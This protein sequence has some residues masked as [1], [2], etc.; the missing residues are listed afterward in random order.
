MTTQTQPAPRRGDLLA[1]WGGILFSLAFT[2]VIA[3]AGWR[4]EAI[5]KWPDAGADWYFWRLMDTTTA[6]RISAWGLYL[7]HQ[8]TAWGL[9]YF[10]QTR[11]KRYVPGLHPINVI[12]LAGNALFIGLHFAQTHL[13]YGGLAEDVSIWSSQVSVII[14]L[15]WVLLMENSRRGLFFGKKVPIS[16][17]II[18]WARKYHGYV[19]AWAAVYTFWYHPMESTWGHLFGF[20]YM[21]LLMLQGSLIFTRAHLNKFWTVTLEAMV[22]AHGTMV[23]VLQGNNLWPMFFFGFTGIFVI[24]Q[25]HGLGWPR[26]AKI[27]VYLLFA[28][29]TVVVYN[30]QWVRLNEIIRIPF[31]EYLSV[32]VLAGLIGGGLWVARRAKQRPLAQS[33]PA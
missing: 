25:M 1:L 4:L 6:A 17:Q 28:A 30:G 23:A 11:V 14:L 13:W 16:K 29:A 26:W 32:F 9:I 19:F 20:F 18:G 31:I 5:P 15:V 33:T 12:A 8:L 27:V 22:A 2:G 21:F 3:L 24:T 10:A 7:L